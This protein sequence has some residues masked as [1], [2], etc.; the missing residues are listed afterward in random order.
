MLDVGRDQ[1]ELALFEN[2]FPSGIRIVPWGIESLGAPAERPAVPFDEPTA[3]DGA[4]RQRLTAMVQAGLN[5]LAGGKDRLSQL[6]DRIGL[7]LHQV[8]RD[9]LG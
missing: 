2:G 3:S 9:S 6:A 1:S 8:H 7:C 5:S 4:D